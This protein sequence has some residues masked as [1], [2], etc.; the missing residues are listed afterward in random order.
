VSPQLP[1]LSR[2][3]RFYLTSFSMHADVRNKSKVNPEYSGDSEYRIINCRGRP[4]C[5][6]DSHLSVQEPKTRRGGVAPP[7][8]YFYY[9]A[10]KNKKQMLYRIINCRGRPPCLPDS[11]LSVQEPKTRRGGVPPPKFYFY[12]TAVKNKHQ[13]LY[14]IINCRGRP[15][16]LPDSLQ[17]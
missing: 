15:A 8:F 13:M 17:A 7:K 9:T 5:L 4:P 3:F 11:H 10:V 16:C 1:W 6:P 2:I 14:R 12:Y